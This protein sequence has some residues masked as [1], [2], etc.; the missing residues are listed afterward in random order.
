MALSVNRRGRRSRST[1]LSHS[2]FYPSRS[3]A[4]GADG[5]SSS[6]CCWRNLLFLLLLV[7][8]ENGS[9]IGKILGS[10]PGSRFHGY[11]PK[12]PGLRMRFGIV[13]YNPTGPIQH[14]LALK[15]SVR[16]FFLFGPACTMEG[17]K[18]PLRC[19]PEMGRNIESFDLK[20]GRLKACLLGRL[21][22][23]NKNAL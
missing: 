21:P 16:Q 9:D 3:P 5:S 4:G 20:E 6:S 23:Q 22:K 14:T 17:G 13:F 10:V 15:V 1:T 19:C 8:E 12:I 11:N 18:N 2:E 7:S